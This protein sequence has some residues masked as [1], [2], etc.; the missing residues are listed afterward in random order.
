MKGRD[1]CAP[2]TKCFRPDVIHLSK[3]QLRILYTAS[4]EAAVEFPLKHHLSNPVNTL[5]DHPEIL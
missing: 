1:C 4:F 2:A 3:G 5:L